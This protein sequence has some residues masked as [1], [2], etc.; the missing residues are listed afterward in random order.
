LKESPL[1]IP[2]N[3]YSFT[4]RPLVE[5]RSFR[6]YVCGPDDQGKIP[7]DPVL[8]KIEHEVIK[9]AFE[10]IIIY[11]DGAKTAQVWQWVKR[12]QG[13]A[14]TTRLHRYYKGQSGEGLAQKLEGLVIAINEEDQ[15]RAADVTG[16]VARAFDVERVTRRFYDR[17]KLEHAAFLKFIQG[18]TAQ[19]DREWYASLML[20]RLMFIYFIQ[21]KGFL[22]TTSPQ[23]LD[24]D[25]NYLANRLRSMQEQ[26]GY[27]PG[28]QFQTL[29]GS[30]GDREGRPY[31]TRINLLL[32][33]MKEEC[34]ACLTRELQ[35]IS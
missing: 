19:G 9:Y 4:L 29:A 3:N 1:F 11:V 17:F 21:R 16:R 10:H 7:A 31:H 18:I 34:V 20:N 5:K 33:N 15:L 8:R 6:V 23:A 32:W 2:V 13:K 14:S 30:K 27:E 35:Y 24:G 12:E 28:N 22:G 25:E 26:Q